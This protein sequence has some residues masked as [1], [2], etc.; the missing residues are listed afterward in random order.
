MMKY[1]PNC[2]CRLNMGTC[3]NKI[4]GIKKSEVE[5]VM[6]S[7]LEGRYTEDELE[8]IISICNDE[9]S[10]LQAIENIKEE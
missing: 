3:S 10:I 1:C 4:G 7:I 6:D 9:I 8:E 2:G 5:L